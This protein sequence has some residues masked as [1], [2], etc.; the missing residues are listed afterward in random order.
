MEFFL[1]VMLFQLLFTY[2]AQNTFAQLHI[3][4]TT[5]KP[6]HSET[7]FSISSSRQEKW[8]RSSLKQIPSLLTIN[9]AA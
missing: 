4:E 1:Y 8:E 9:Q 5:F 3:H 7:S 6:I 2:Y